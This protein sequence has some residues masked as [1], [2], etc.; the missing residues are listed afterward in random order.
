MGIGAGAAARDIA[1]KGW[2]S[3]SIKI[4]AGAATGGSIGVSKVAPSAVRRANGTRNLTD[5]A[6]HNQKRTLAPLRC[7]ASA[8]RPAPP[9]HSEDCH[10]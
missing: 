7:N 2:A 10:K 8:S 3:G 6:N 5:A 4:T 1:E 9:T